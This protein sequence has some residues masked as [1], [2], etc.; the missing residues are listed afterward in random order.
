MYKI[1]LLKN[2]N[3]ANVGLEINAGFFCTLYDV[4]K[5]KIAHTV[6]PLEEPNP[7]LYLIKS[8]FETNNEIVVFLQNHDK[9]SVT[10]VRVIFDA[11]TGAFK[12]KELIRKMPYDIKKFYSGPEVYLDKPEYYVQ[13]DLN[14]EYY[15]VV[16]FDSFSKDINKTIEVIHY[17]PTHEV[18]STLFV[19]KPEEEFSNV[20]FVNM[21]ING[22]NSVILYTYFYNK[23]EKKA[24]FYLSELK[25]G[26]SISKYK[27]AV[28][29]SHYVLGEGNFMYDNVAKKLKLITTVLDME[30]KDYYTMIQTLNLETL[31]L[32]EQFIFYSE[33]TNSKYKVVDPKANYRGVVQNVC[34]DAKGDLVV[35]SE[36]ITIYTTEVS[37][38]IEAQEIGVA[39]YTSTG[40]EKYGELVHYS[41]RQFLKVNSLLYTNVSSGQYKYAVLDEYDATY[42]G[43]VPGKKNTYLLLNNTPER[44]DVAQDKWPGFRT[45]LNASKEHFTSY[46]YTLNDAGIVSKEYIFGKPT[47]VE[48]TQYCLFQTA[49]FNPETGM[50]AVV[51]IDRVKGKRTSRVLWMNLN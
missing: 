8:L 36:M 27:R 29:S 51:V 20:S 9:V 43:L 47:V 46:I 37:R 30:S 23:K 24:C 10:L 45:L 1:K 34:I 13:F 40:K 14:S 15:A 6:V 49:D 3:T 26:G 41:H 38:F 7:R 4:N 39:G 35:L 42:L 18:L 5:K 19:S 33:K 2:G 25:A 48:E 11:S 44:S 32:T 31:T 17:S 28:E 12:K 16:Y 50:Y 22:A 21:Y